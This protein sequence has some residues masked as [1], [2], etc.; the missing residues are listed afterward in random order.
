MIT[1]TEINSLFDT[2]FE[3]MSILLWLQVAL[4]KGVNVV[5][6]VSRSLNLSLR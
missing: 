6:K 1:F 5:L 2:K 4:S 3:A